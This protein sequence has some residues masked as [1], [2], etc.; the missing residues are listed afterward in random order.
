MKVLVIGNGIGGFSAAST[1]RRLNDRCDVTMISMERTPLYSPC[2]LPDYISGK[3]PREGVF[4]KQSKEYKRLGIQTLLGHRVEEIDP[5]ARTVSLHDGQNLSFDSLV[6]ATGS[7]AIPFSKPRKGIFT[8][9]TLKD[10]D[11][12][13]RHTAKKAVVIGAG[14][15]GIEVALSLYRRGSSVTIIEML[16][17]ILPLGLDRRGADKVKGILEEK[18]I[19]VFNGERAE[20]V[21]GKNKVEGLVTNQRELEC[22]TLI[23]SV[24]MR[25]R[26]DLARQAGIAI[27]DKGGIRVNSH[28][29]T[30]LPGIYACGD[31]VESTDMLTGEPHLNLFWHNANRQGAVAAHNCTGVAREYPGS[32]N[33][34]NV[35][36]FENH[37]VGFGFTE[38]NLRRFKDGSA[39]GGELSGSDLSIIE[40]EK[41]GSYHRL[42][43]VRDRCVGGQF[44]N[45]KGDLGL[46]WSLMFQ[47]RSIKELLG[48]FENQDRM[49]RR[50]W[51]QRV[52]P[53][54]LNAEN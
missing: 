35:D 49:V 22:D 38:A 2:V 29:E 26:V 52:K 13:V 31:C 11:Q 42:V 18:G 16:D 28:M 33:I 6:L 3:I 21:L 24:G 5:I 19:D 34:L 32:Q 10:A 15:V 45:V 47:G 30:S 53:F 20:T 8:L 44:I 23:W 27:G 51:L 37:V 36:V 1:V 7:D 50:S 25:P 14:A 48:M 40:N 17:Q 54:F 46:L 9:K 43:I 12:I 4:V 39:L 41:D